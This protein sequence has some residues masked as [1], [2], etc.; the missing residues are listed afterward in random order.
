MIPMAAAVALIGADCFAP[1]DS[2]TIAMVRT[3]IQIGALVG[4]AILY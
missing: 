4:V 3:L 1:H 2:V